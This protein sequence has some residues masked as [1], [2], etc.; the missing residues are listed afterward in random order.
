MKNRY[1]VA[2]NAIKYAEKALEDLKTFSNTQ[3]EEK[4]ETM[5]D[6]II[7][8]VVNTLSNVNYMCCGFK[9]QHLALSNMKTKF[10]FYIYDNSAIGSG[11]PIFSITTD[12]DVEYS[13]DLNEWMMLTLV[14]EWDGFKKEFD[15]AIKTTLESRKKYIHDQMCHIGYVNEQLSKWHI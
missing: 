8:Y 13:N 15:F 7:D 4:G 9:I 3:Y 5:L 14:K 1:E 12:G 11:Y 2:S 10:I 6:Q